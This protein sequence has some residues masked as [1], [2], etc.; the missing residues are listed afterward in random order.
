MAVSLQM[1]K[2]RSRMS[3]RGGAQI[4]FVRAAEDWVVLRL[5]LAQNDLNSL[6][7][8]ARQLLAE[9]AFE[10]PKRCHDPSRPQT[11]CIS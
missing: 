11:Q 2:W 4:D 1:A 3:G 9:I 5:A 7:T 10:E 6:S 8:H